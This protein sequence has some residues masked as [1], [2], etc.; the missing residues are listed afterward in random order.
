MKNK[1][2][3]ELIREEIL[4]IKK[5]LKEIAESPTAVRT[6]GPF[7]GSGGIGGPPTRPTGGSGPS[8]STWDEIPPSDEDAWMIDFMQAAPSCTSPGYGSCGGGDICI[9]SN[10]FGNKCVPD[11]SNSGVPLLMKH[12][13]PSSRLP[14]GDQ[15]LLLEFPW[16]AFIRVLS[17]P[18]GIDYGPDSPHTNYSNVRPKDDDPTKPGYSDMAMGESKQYSR[19]KTLA[20][21]KSLHGINNLKEKRNK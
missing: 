5:K 14:E 4:G 6:H 13:P 16:G 7:S 8:G 3:K 21:I 20:G 1:R 15:S 18:K 9:S 17:F 12:T 2:L 11:W 19:L 10:K